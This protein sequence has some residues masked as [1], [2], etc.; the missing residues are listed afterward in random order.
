[1]RQSS[2]GRFT[3]PVK[4]ARDLFAIPWEVFGVAFIS[5]RFVLI[6]GARAFG[7]FGRRRRKRYPIR[8]FGPIGR[9]GPNQPLRLSSARD[10]S[11]CRNTAATD[12]LRRRRPESGR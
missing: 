9:T 1:M 2:R 12:E 5:S 11:E 6:G 10:S 7:L 3:R 4:Y 8:R